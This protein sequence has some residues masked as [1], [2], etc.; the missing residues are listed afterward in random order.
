MAELTIIEYTELAVWDVKNHFRL[1]NIFKDNLPLVLFGEFLSKPIIEKTKIIDDK[2]YKVLG[3]RSYG[4]GTFINRTVKGDT[5]KMRTYQI[6]PKDHLF[7]CK[8]DTKNGAFGII[9]DR[10]E[11]GIASSN[12]TFASID[13]SKVLIDYVQLLFKSPMVNQYMDGYVTGSTNRKYIKPDQLLNEIKIPLPSINEQ[14][15]IIDN[16]YHHFI[17]AENQEKEIMQLENEIE[18]ILFKELGLDKID[19]KVSKVGLS[20][21]YYTEIVEWGYNI[22]NSRFQSNIYKTT[23]LSSSPDLFKE[24]FR[25]KSPKYDIEGNSTILN[26]K[27]NRWNALDLSYVK[28]VNDKWYNKIDEKFFTKEGDVLINSTGDGT[29]GRATMITS[30]N[31]NLL[32][33]SHLLLLRLDKSKVNPLFF[34]YL[35]NSKYGQYQVESIKSAQSTKQ[36]ELGI[37]NLKKIIFPLP[38]IQLQNTIANKLQSIYQRIEILK[39]NAL[40]NRK[41]ALVKFEQEIFSD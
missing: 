25:G 15:R 16:Y 32:Y 26:Q 6:A 35:F 23:S 18:T 21:V 12:M 19:N 41:D 28:T 13:K 38:S 20:F 8:V 39:V 27:C 14:K 30:E 3:V 1:Q 31:E 36:T 24:A 29:I 22:D 33:D 2:E 34:T 5:L 9:D 37:T 7:W 40:N 4:K 17:I 10:F 11:K